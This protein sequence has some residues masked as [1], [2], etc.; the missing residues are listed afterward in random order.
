[1]SEPKLTATSKQKTYQLIVMVETKEFGKHG[2][3][4][5]PQWTNKRKMLTAYKQLQTQIP[6]LEWIET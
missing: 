4:L 3:T 2:I 5:T 6:N 1:M